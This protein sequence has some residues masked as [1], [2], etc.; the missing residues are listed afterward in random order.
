MSTYNED[1]DA[2]GVEMLT[3]YGQEDRFPTL[4][5]NPPEIT[6]S[7]LHTNL[8]RMSSYQ[9]EKLMEWMPQDHEWF[10]DVAGAYGIVRERED[11]DFEDGEVETDEEL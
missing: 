7:L 5:Y 11:E 3:V 1:G 6:Q 8:E 4:R 10:P 9:L 2:T